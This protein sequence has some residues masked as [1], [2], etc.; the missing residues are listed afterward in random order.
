MQ[1]SCAMQFGQTGQY[2]EVN[3]ACRNKVRL[4]SSVLKL[5]M[6]WFQIHLCKLNREPGGFRYSQ[7]WKLS[8]GAKGR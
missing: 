5:G 2:N 7:R 6:T 4:I 8:N 1:H 3:L